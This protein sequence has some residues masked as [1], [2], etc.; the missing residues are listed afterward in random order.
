MNN[1]LISKEEILLKLQEISEQLDQLET[2]IQTKCFAEQQIE[3]S[4]HTEKL[5][6]VNNEL[7]QIEKKI[8]T[9]KEN[10]GVKCLKAV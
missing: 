7:I 10:F 6:T 9:D 1:K 4:K 3:V 5:E 2:E 8:E